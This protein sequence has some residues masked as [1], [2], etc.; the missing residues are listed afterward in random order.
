MRTPAKNAKLY[1]NSV[2]APMRKRIIKAFFRTE[3]VALKTGLTHEQ[4][5]FIYFE[6]CH[7]MSHVMFS[8]LMINDEKFRN[9]VVASYL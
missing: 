2:L 9:D 7:T 3:R 6:V 5:D 4:V 8:R 1:M